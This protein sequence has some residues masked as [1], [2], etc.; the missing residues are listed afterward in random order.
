MNKSLLILSFLMAVILLMAVNVQ[1]AE[2]KT[3]A[4][5]EFENSI[6]RYY[7]QTRGIEKTVQDRLNTLLTKSDKFRVVEKDIIREII[8]E[9]KFSVSGLVDEAET[10][11]E[12]GKLIGADHIITG[13]LN[14]LSVN[15]EKFS[16][17][18]TTIYNVR[19]GME[20][21]IR[22]INVTTGIIEMANS[23]KVEKMFQGK[24]AS[25]IDIRTVSD[26]LLNEI[27]NEFERDINNY[28]FV[29]AESRGEVQVSFSSKPSGASIEVDGLYLGNTPLKIPVDSGVHKI[30][31]FMGGYEPWQMTV[32]INQDMNNIEVNLGLAE[33]YE[34]E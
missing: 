10:A 7:H 9:Q 22:L 12:L 6:G 25:S 34:G 33:N 8:Q 16:G 2:I 4:I 24:R 17:Y 5:I 3:A 30:R 20:S 32:D 14:T 21:S 27:I 28:Q 1:A 19:A 13:T 23:Y 15:E 18:D 29:D 31:I 11:I 26:D